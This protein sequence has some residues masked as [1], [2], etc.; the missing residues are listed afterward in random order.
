MRKPIVFA[1]PS[2][3][4]VDRD[5]LQEITLLPPAGKGDLLAA[6]LAGATAIGLIDGTFEF[7]AAIWHKEILF[8]LDRGIPVLGAAS[9]GALRGA[10]CAAFGMIGIGSVYADYAAGRRQSDADVAVVHAPAELGY[11]PL[12]EALVDIDATLRHLSEARLLSPDLVAKLSDAAAATHF[13]DRTWPLI[14]ARAGFDGDEGG[15]ILDLVQVC[16][17]SAKTTD[18]LAL[19]D[20]IRTLPG[21]DTSKSRLP[22]EFNR[23]LFFQG[24]EQEVRGRMT[25]GERQ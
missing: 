3:H 4:G 14:L 7:G 25:D 2:L 6:A 16:R 9:M 15:E 22:A 11:R 8:A 1:G 19:L 20:T 10:E 17:I 12:C 13:K 5:L 23:T 18:A 24:L 21:S